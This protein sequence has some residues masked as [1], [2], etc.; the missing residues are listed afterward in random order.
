MQRTGSIRWRLAL[1]LVATSVA[2]LLFAILVA[3][4]MVQQ[5][6][7][8]FY[9]PEI[10]MR[11][12]QSLSLYQELADTVKQSLRNAADAIAANER[13]RHAVENNDTAAVRRELLAALRQYPTVA[14]LTVQGS[15]DE[16]MAR[17]DRGLAVDEAKEKRLDVVRH[18]SANGTEGPQLS[19]VFAVGRTR[20]DE[21]ESMANFLQA[22]R[23]IEQRRLQDELAYLKAFAVLMGLTALIALGLGL[24]LSGNVTRRLSQLA[25]ATRRVALGDLN[26]QVVDRSKDEIGAL[27]RA[28]NRMVR[29]VESSRARIEYLQRIGAWQEMARR[30][31]HEIKNP[32]TPIQLAVQEI[33]QRCPRSDPAFS[34]LVDTTREIVEDEVG[35]LRRLV[36]EFSNFARLPQAQLQLADLCDFLRLQQRK[37]ESADDDDG[38]LDPGAAPSALVRQLKL[39]L[40]L[41]P[42][43]AMAHFDAQMLGRTLVN[44][45]QNAAQAIAAHHPTDGKIV[46]RL[47]RD[48]DYW[49][50]DVDDNGPGIPNILR[51]SVFDPYVTTKATGTG[52]GLAIA[53]KIVV[54]HGGTILALT[55]DWGGARLRLTIPVAGT[56][57]AEMALK[58]TVYESSSAGN[59]S[60]ESSA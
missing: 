39:Q 38:L 45:I 37:F 10:G 6:A 9:L 11:L 26:A 15:D 14:E 3:K 5:T 2:P 46:I 22:Y 52:L 59:S 31:A 32:L 44:L 42:G 56:A 4:S 17:V 12:D 35:T 7:D 51:S 58:A 8:R 20:F 48:E 25:T 16:I 23:R 49:T 50:I 47:S 13:L 34:K 1:A 21:Q 33:Q 36:T 27:A 29:E 30:L 57:A 28:F 43:A 41:P 60:L 53:K 19:L 40:E 54:E 55:N 18:L 24:A